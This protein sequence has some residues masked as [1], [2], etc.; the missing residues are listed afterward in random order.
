MTTIFSSK[1]RALLAAS[2]LASCLALAACGGSDDKKSS[3]KGGDKPA[4]TAAEPAPK[5]D[6]AAQGNAL[7]AKVATDMQELAAAE[8]LEGVAARGSVFVTDLSSLEPP[9]DQQEQFDKLLELAQAN[10]EEVASIVADGGTAEDLSA[11]DET[12][13]DALA[14]DLGLTTCAS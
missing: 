5:D 12:E 13:L 7:C 6:F 1:L 9:A 2:A 4:A 11:I 10:N 14:T 3:D 8:D